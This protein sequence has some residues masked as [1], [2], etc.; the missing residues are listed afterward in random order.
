[1]PRVV[2]AAVSMFLVGACSLSKPTV[3]VLATNE[4]RSEE[5]RAAAVE[6]VLVEQTVEL[7]GW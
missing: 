1:M 4:I 3:C 2:L 5:K 6:S 7:L